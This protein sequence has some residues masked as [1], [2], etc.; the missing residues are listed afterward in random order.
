MKESIHKQFSSETEEIQD[1]GELIQLAIEDIKTT[2][3]GELVTKEISSLRKIKDHEANLFYD[4]EINEILAMVKSQRDFYH[5][6]TSDLEKENFKAMGY[7]LKEDD[8]EI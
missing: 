2:V 3:A 8:K 1:L 7:I 6:K 4:S 5:S